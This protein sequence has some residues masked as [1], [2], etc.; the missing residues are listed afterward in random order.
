M[1]NRCTLALSMASNTFIAPR[2]TL[3]QDPHSYH[4]AMVHRRTAREVDKRL[5]F[6][7]HSLGPIFPALPTRPGTED[8]PVRFLGI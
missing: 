8:H 6:V 1:T 3:G 2:I 5:T 4:S 7:I